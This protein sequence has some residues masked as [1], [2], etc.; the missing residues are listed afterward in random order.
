M[1]YTEQTIEERAT[2]QIGQYQH[3]SQREIAR[4]LGQSPSTISRELG[5]NR[6][7]TA[8]YSALEARALSRI[9]Q[10]LPWVFEAR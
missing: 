7:P 8:S 5:R 4:L 2:I 1:S 3:L 10:R 9:H 6:P